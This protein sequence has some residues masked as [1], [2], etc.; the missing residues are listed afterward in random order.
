MDGVEPP[1]PPK[2]RKGNVYNAEQLNRLLDQA[3]GSSVRI[4][5]V[6]GVHTGMRLGE[7][8]ALQWD[9]VDLDA[10]TVYVH[11]SLT[12]TKRDGLEFKSTKNEDSRLMPLPTDATAELRRHQAEQAQRRLLLDD[13]W[14]DHGLVWPKDDGT[15]RNPDQASHTYHD[16]I[17]RTDL[18][19]YRFHDLRHTHAT[20]LGHAKIDKKVVQERLGHKTLAITSDLYTKVFA[21]AH[22]EAADAMDRI[23]RKA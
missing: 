2:H 20:L 12:H 6:L 21:S 19:P 16:F 13:F 1:R 4:A 18:P 23:L 3:R 7:I 8:C 11:Q 10:G 15:P 14:Q 22:Q 5:V 17:R 9:D